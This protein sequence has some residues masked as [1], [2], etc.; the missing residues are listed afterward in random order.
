MKNI[1]KISRL[2]I[3]L[4]IVVICF[5]QCTKEEIDVVDCNNVTSTYTSNVKSTLDANCATSG[6]HNSSSKKSGYDLSTYEATKA[7]AGN[8]AFVGSVQHK[9]GYSKMPRGASK[10]SEAEI[11]LI[12]CWVQSGMPQ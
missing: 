3:A 5:S 4:L 11:K 8:E 2:V 10:L 9:S 7:A 1:F 6:C 12:A